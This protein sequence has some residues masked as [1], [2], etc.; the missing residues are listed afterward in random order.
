LD[1]KHLDSL[2]LNNYFSIYI[3]NKHLFVDYRKMK[4]IKKKSSSP[5]TDVGFDVYIETLI[6]GQKDMSKWLPS[7]KTS[8][9]GCRT[10][11]GV[12]DLIRNAAL[13]G[14]HVQDVEDIFSNVSNVL[15]TH[16]N[17]DNLDKQGRLESSIKEYIRK[18]EEYKYFLPNELVELSNDTDND[19][20]NLKK[21]DF[22]I[23]YKSELDSVMRVIRSVLVS[24]RDEKI[25]FWNGILELY[26]EDKE[27]YDLEF[28]T[29]RTRHKKDLEWVSKIDI[30]EYA[31]RFKRVG[32]KDKN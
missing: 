5:F 7:D 11:V 3:V 14:S 24:L 6:N 23:G 17:Q 27:A 4:K 22:D 31:E 1:K 21:L 12:F 19:K 2:N 20:G 9:L 10:L 28:R 16:F 25:A 32:K 26:N 29:K 15:F 8:E 30:D 13:R 18:L